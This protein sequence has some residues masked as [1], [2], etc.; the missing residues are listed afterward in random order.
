[1]LNLSFL[2]VFFVRLEKLGVCYRSGEIIGKI[3]WRIQF[4]KVIVSTCM[5]MCC[6]FYAVYVVYMQYTIIFLIS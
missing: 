4:Y 3:Y 6:S 5:Y 2:E 1:M